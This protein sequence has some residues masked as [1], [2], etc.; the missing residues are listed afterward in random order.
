MA[1]GRLEIGQEALVEQ[2]ETLA[3]LAGFLINFLDEH[4]YT[5]FG[6]FFLLKIVGKQLGVIELEELIET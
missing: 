3:L 6:V 4:Q 5:I 1:F 2:I